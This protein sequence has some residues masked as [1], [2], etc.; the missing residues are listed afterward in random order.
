MIVRHIAEFDTSFPDDGIE[1]EHDLIQFPGRNIAA[2][3]AEILQGLGYTVEGPVN[4]GDHGWGVGIKTQGRWFWCE[5]T[6]V[7]RHLLQVLNRS[8]TD[9]L[10]RRTPKTY[11]EILKALAAALSADPRFWNISWYSR[12]EYGRD[13][14]GA[15]HPVD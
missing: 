12:E 7:E 8:L 14:P 4:A 6:I 2:A 13:A 15:T 5:V 9:K 11:L 1:D 3:V 10:L